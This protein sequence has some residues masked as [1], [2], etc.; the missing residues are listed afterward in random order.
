M[1]PRRPPSL[2]CSST[3]RPKGACTLLLSSAAALLA[4]PVIRTSLER[5]AG[6]WVTVAADA[7]DVLATIHVE[8]GSPVHCLSVVGRSTLPVTRHALCSVRRLWPC[9]NTSARTSVDSIFITNRRDATLLALPE[10][11]SC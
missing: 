11:Q 10:L 1:D 4:S 7:Q 2:T 3:T 6:A 9:P 8:H 5:W